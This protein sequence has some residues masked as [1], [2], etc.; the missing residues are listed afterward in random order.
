[1]ALLYQALSSLS[2]SPLQ[3]GIQATSTSGTTQGVD[4]NP[5]RVWEVFLLISAGAGISP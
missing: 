2:S 3:Q 4:L 1:M 5:A